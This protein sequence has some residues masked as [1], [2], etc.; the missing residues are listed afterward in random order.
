MAI[1]SGILHF[2]GLK[3]KENIV[4]SK[5]AALRYNQS[6]NLPD[7]SF[8]AQ[9]DFGTI[10]SSFGPSYSFKGLTASSSGPIR[11]KQSWDAAFGSLYLANIQWDV[12]AFGKARKKVQLGLEILNS[13][14]SDLEQEIFEHK[15]KIA[16][17]YLQ[18]LS[19]ESFINLQKA[20]LK[21]ANQIRTL[22]ISRTRSG[23]NPGVDS[24]IANAEVS[25]AKIALIHAQE[26]AKEYQTELNYLM[27]IKPQL[28][29]LD[30]SFN[31]MIP[32]K[33]EMTEII[34][35]IHPVLNY[36]KSLINQE[37][38]QINYFRANS[39]PVF[40]LFDLLQTR[41]SGFSNS[42]GDASPTSF[43]QNY[44]T[45]INPIRSNYLIGIGLFWSFTNTLKNNHIIEEHKFLLEA[46]KN[47][48]DLINQRLKANLAISND[49]LSS[50]LKEF[51]ESPIQLKA[52]ENAFL[53]KSVLF[54]NGLNNLIDLSQT[55]YNLNQAENQLVISYNN[56]WSALLIQSAAAGDFN[57]FLNQIPSKKSN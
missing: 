30:T 46:A 37:N 39:F 47:N 29:Q 17:A 21:R 52:A 4:H 53:Q 3:I 13:S 26:L 12:F 20:N 25:N 38:H 15:I 5:E 45:G 11:S 57:L 34:K 28:F 51:Q 19:A 9:Q 35:P 40:T 31:Q 36:Y 50:A 8:S 22:V 10:N 24:S 41:G 27:G 44:G 2:P 23:L 7:L 55:L 18:L 54:K 1:D 6:E 16:S 42:Y 14:K 32:E 56:V 49:R 43:S 48:Y 33:L